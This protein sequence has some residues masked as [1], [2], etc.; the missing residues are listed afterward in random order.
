VDQL[1]SIDN[2]PFL[3]VEVDADGVRTPL[4]VN[5]T[6]D[7]L[8]LSHCF[9]PGGRRTFEAGERNLRAK[10]NCLFHR[11]RFVPEDRAPRRQEASQPI[12]LGIIFVPGEQG[13]SRVRE[14]HTNVQARCG[15]ADGRPYQPIPIGIARTPVERGGAVGERR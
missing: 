9:L 2:P 14:A 10:S 7:V 13:A 15:P 11:D 4:P 5:L 6:E 3:L 12:A 8:E 1:Q